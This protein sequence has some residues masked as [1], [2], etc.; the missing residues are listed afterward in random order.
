MR[1]AAAFHLVATFL[2]VALGSDQGRAAPA[3]V[4]TEKSRHWAFVPPVRPALPPV[5]RSERA[6]NAIDRFVLA[7]LEKEGLT[8]SPEADRVTLIRRLSLDLLGLPPRPDEVDAF[9]RDRRPD[10]WERLVDRCLASPHYGER[11]GR[12]WLDGARYAD[13]NGYSID[14]PRSI[15]KYRDWVIEAFNRDL[16]FDAFAVWQLAGDLLPEATPEQKIATGFH[17]NTQI[18]QEGGIDPEQFRVES[19]MD[20]VNTT[21]TVFLGVTLACAQCHDHKFDPFT[22]REYYQM[23]AFFNSSEQDGHGKGDFGPV[24]ELPVPEEKA[25]IE[26]HRRRVRKLEEELDARGDELRGKAGSWE[27]G[28]DAPARAKLKPETQAA[29]AVAPDQRTAAQNESV[30]AAFRDQDL[31]YGKL[32]ERLA[33]L[34]KEMPGV[35]TTLVMQELPEPRETHAFR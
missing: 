28:L 5:R 8:P 24:L 19:V 25:A 27:A 6:R 21:A 9:V 14:A 3:D 33:K 34:K 31:E 10:A 4:T 17:R 20:R 35:T 29:L 1:A 15:W 30:F 18:N 23:F 12:W 16:P 7:R 26:T 13:S 2:L 32:R 11:W 22:Q